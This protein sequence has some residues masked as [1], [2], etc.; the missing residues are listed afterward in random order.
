MGALLMRTDVVADLPRPW[1]LHG[2]NAHGGD[3]GEDVMFC[4][5]LGRAGHTV[6]IDHDLSKQVGH[7]GQHT[8]RIQT[9][10]AAAV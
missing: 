6:Y 10:D 4:R 2:I 5:G 3:V 7:I 1:F 9:E 8:Y